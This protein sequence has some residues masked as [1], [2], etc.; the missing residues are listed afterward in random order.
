MS[1]HAKHRWQCHCNLGGGSRGGARWAPR[2]LFLEE[3]EAQSAE[4]KFWRPPLPLIS[5]S[6]SGLKQETMQSTLLTQ[7]FAAHKDEED[8]SQENYINCQTFTYIL[9]RQWIPLLNCTFNVD[10]TK[11]Q[12]I[13]RKKTVTTNCR[14]VHPF[15]LQSWT[16]VL[17][18]VLQY[19]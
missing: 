16:N 1:R 17:G 12:I 3:T 10:K 18:T 9:R 6:G 11:I 14:I 7:L 15:K 2:P 19:S 4:K 8:V 13:Y 5:G